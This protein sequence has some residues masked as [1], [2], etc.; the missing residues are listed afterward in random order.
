[1]VTGIDVESSSKY[2]MAEGASMAWKDIPG[3]EDRPGYSLF[4]QSLQKPVNDDRE[5]RMIRLQNG[6]TAVLVHD[7]R[8]DKAAASLSIAV[9]HLQDP[10]S[11]QY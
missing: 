3:T 10:V 8:T 5:Y 1:M 2:S 11:G 7:A 6:L 9:G 4:C